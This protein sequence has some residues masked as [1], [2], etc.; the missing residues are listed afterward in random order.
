MDEDLSYEYAL[1]SFISD[2]SKNASSLVSELASRDVSIRSHSVDMDHMSPVSTERW[3]R[4]TSSQGSIERRTSNLS[5]SLS[6][7]RYSRHFSES[8][9]Y[10]ADFESL[11]KDESDEDEEAVTVCSVASD[12]DTQTCSS[13]SQELS[14]RLHSGDE[15]EDLSSDSHHL[16]SQD[17]SNV[18]R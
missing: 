9:T 5:A 7:L 14:T 17:S 12:T 1:D 6:M 16:S 8:E 18:L 13:V 11:S 2:S 15:I 10:S 4:R 3:G